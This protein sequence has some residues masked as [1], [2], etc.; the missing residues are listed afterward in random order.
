MLIQR[1]I[2]H[3]HSFDGKGRIIDWLEL[4]WHETTKRILRK[5]TR[6]GTEVSLKFLN[7]N[8]FLGEGDILYENEQMII[9]VS[10][11]PC[12]VIVIKPGSMFEMASVCYEIGNKHLLLFYEHDELLVPFELPLFRLLEARGYT[13]KRDER[14]LVQPLITTVSPHIHRSGE[15]LFSKIMKITTSDE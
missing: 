13:A 11:L 14:K 8:P 6:S 2:G 3:I 1:K 7:E 10:I 12:E 4:E 15:T 5:R 9:A